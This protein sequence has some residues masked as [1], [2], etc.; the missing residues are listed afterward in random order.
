[1]MVELDEIF[2]NG[3]EGTVASDT[4]PEGLQCRPRGI[5]RGSPILVGI[6][7]IDKKFLFSKRK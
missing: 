6:P 5:P 7:D 3:V 4:L 1:M 2:G